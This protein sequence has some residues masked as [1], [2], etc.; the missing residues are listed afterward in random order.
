MGQ[1]AIAVHR[2]GPYEAP[3]PFAYMSQAQADFRAIWTGNQ[4]YLEGE[5]DHDAV[6]RFVRFNEPWKRK[7]PYPPIV[8]RLFAGVN[9][10][11]PSH[12][13]VLWLLAGP[14]CALLSTF[15]AAPSLYPGAGSSGQAVRA[16]VLLGLLGSTALAFQM[17]RGNFD[18]VV[19]ALYMVAL[20][21]MSQ[22]KS[23]AG[24]VLL[25]VATCLKL[26]PGVMLLLLVALRRRTAL[27]AA[28]GTAALV[29][30][31]TSPLDN[32][33]WLSAL[34]ADRATSFGLH[35]GNASLANLIGALGIVRRSAL[36]PV[37]LALFSLL[38]LAVVAA[39]LIRRRRAALDVARLGVCVLPFMF[40]M[41]LTHWSYA[42]F[43][44]MA[45]LPALAAVYEERP[46]LRWPVIA[47]AALVGLCQAPVVAWRAYP[48]WRPV[49]MPIY[50]GCV[51][52][53]GL[54]AIWLV[55]CG[56]A[57]A[58]PPRPAD[59]ARGPADG[60]ACAPAQV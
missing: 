1:V 51:L 53:L 46:G 36:P 9:L 11:R 37:S 38:V 20:A 33:Q 30:I 7:Y 6:R 41:P 39:A 2:G 17:E 25:G 45:M 54:L 50:G 49:V 22:G 55:A 34:A 18:W 56:A 16:L 32:W 29:V 15:A 52:L 48:G 5:P 43:A 12:A 35:P 57:D 24:G 23:V 19:F 14:F 13:S 59:G 8:Y 60:P 58:P 40:M 28:L 26:Y 42:L 21:G 4:A 47:T 27:L 44:L 10:L 3:F 31:V